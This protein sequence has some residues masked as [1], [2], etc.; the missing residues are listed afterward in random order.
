MRLLLT[1]PLDDAQPLARRLRK[2]GHQVDLAPVLSINL[3]PENLPKGDRPAVLAVT[4]KN[5]IRAL[6]ALPVSRRRI[7]Q[8][9][10]LYAVGPATANAAR[11][12]GWHRVMAAQGDVADLAACL[13]KEHPAGVIWHVS[14][15]VQAGALVD[16]LTAE[17]LPAKRVI[18]YR[19]EPVADWPRHVAAR[20]PDYDG[21]IIYSKRSA[22]LFCEQAALILQQ[23]RDADQGAP[24]LPTA[25]CLSHGVADA[26]RASGYDA[27][28]AAEP[29]D[30]AICAL[31]NQLG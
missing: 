31:I 3:S 11:R 17:G 26:V 14:G 5:G 15:A 21:V 29:S 10:P 27:R 13:I 9:L 16:T 28:V 22:Q 7:L 25:Y 30:E 24:V 12:A 18:L 8:R 2:Y 23:Q 1:R 4:S 6:M 20:Y 19:A